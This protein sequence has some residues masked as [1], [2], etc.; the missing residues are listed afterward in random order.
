M[1]PPEKRLETS[2]S[3]QP[4]ILNFLKSTVT[5]INH[6]EE[7]KIESSLVIL[8]ST[9]RECTSAESLEVNVCQ[10][11][12]LAMK[13]SL[14]FKEEVILSP[15]Q[16]DIDYPSKQYG[17][18]I[19]NFYFRIIKILHGFI[20]TLKE[21]VYYVIFVKV[22]EYLEWDFIQ[23]KMKRHSVQMVFQT[24]KSQFQ[25]FVDMSPP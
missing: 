15:Y 2:S 24:G 9:E 25:I 16:P 3:S 22:S 10:N 11:S 13:N 20:G 19:E 5:K 21:S 7:T 12:P 14:T 17:K 4:S 8:D 6:V 1:E 18:K 23:Q